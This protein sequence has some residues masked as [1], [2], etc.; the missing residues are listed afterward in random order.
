MSMS[1]QVNS[2]C[3]T[4]NLH[5][6]NIVRIRKYIDQDTCHHVVR[7]L[8]TSRLDYSNSLLYGIAKENLR[9]LTGIQYRAAKQC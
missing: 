8:V 9:R 5:L 3:R 6:R 1:S 7:S 2:I 4:T